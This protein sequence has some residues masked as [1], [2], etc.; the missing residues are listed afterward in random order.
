MLPKRSLYNAQ[1]VK[2]NGKVIFMYLSYMQ[3]SLYFCERMSLWDNGN[4]ILTLIGVNRER[5]VVWQIAACY[6]D[7][8]DTV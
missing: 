7:F 5:S 4:D 2:R 3:T 1:T 6:A 8:G